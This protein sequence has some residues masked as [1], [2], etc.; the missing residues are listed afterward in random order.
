MRVRIASTE[1]TK[2]LAP[3]GGIQW[4]P[5]SFFNKNNVRLNIF[6]S[7]NYINEHNAEIV[8]L[9]I[10]M[11]PSALHPIQPLSA[12]RI[13]PANTPDLGARQQ[14]I[15]LRI[16]AEGKVGVDA[17]SQEY[18]V[19]RQQ[20]RRDLAVLCNR[21]LARRTH[22]GAGRSVSVANIEYESRR[23]L[24]K[25]EKQ[26]IGRLAAQLVTDNCS[27]ALNIGT[28]TEA[29]A[30]ALYGH[31]NLMVLTNNLNILQAM[32]RVSGKQ[33]VLVGGT[34]RAEDG[35]V[36]GGA[37]VDFIQRYKVDY[38]V[39]GASALDDDGAILDFDSREVDVARAILA[40]ARTRILVADSSKFQRQAPI[41]ICSV[42]DLDYVVTDRM[43]SVQFCDAARDAGTQ[44]ISS[45]RK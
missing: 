4:T 36:V 11:P 45:D 40:N 3:I 15:L 38:A 5:T 10:T 43:P 41:R 18:G 32:S 33:L 19:T 39:I 31:E 21:G 44:I 30:N 13:K 7:K 20:I 16:Q 24:A 1:S 22:G 42:G 17:L 35:A 28:T 2:F 23:N 26:V 29:V 9:K 8:R 6:F 25:A 14:S 27:V 12:D 34:V 37:A